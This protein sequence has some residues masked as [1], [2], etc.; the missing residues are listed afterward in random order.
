MLHRGDPFPY[1]CKYYSPVESDHHSNTWE[2]DRHIY[3]PLFRLSHRLQHEP[4]GLQGLPE[5]IG[6]QRTEALKDS[7]SHE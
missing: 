5:R 1:I 7:L 2:I 6:P 3:P 4:R